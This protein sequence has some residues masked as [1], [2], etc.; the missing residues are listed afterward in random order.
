MK[1]KIKCK[2]I[3]KALKSVSKTL[4]K[5]TSTPVMKVLNPVATVANSQPGQKVGAA[6]LGGAALKSV[7]SLKTVADARAISDKVS[8]AKAQ[9]SN[10]T[11]S[12]GAKSKQAGILA[13]LFKT[14]K[15]ASGSPSPTDTSADTTAAAQEAAGAV[16]GGGSSSSVG[17]IDKAF[18]KV[19]GPKTA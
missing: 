17:L 5:V 12:V 8:A 11:A 14:N 16:T 15:Q 4:T 1:L 18:D 19:F 10:V 2:A 9:V 6:I 3:S 13:G 7:T